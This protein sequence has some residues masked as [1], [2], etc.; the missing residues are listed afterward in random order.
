MLTFCDALHKTK[1]KCIQTLESV[2]YTLEI[3][4]KNIIAFYDQLSNTYKHYVS[5]WYWVTG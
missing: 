4:L 5:L 2:Q 1:Q 3:I